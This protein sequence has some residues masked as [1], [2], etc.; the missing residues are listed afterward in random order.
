MIGKKKNSK[1]AYA[2]FITKKRDPPVRIQPCDEH[3]RFMST[4]KSKKK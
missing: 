4:R 3:G 2:G 1:M